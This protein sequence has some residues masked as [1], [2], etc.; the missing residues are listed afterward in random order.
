MLDIRP[1]DVLISPHMLKKQHMEPTPLHLG[2][3]ERQIVESLYRLE[4]AS[5]ADVRAAL[6]DPPSY[7]AVRAVLNLLVH[8]GML[9]VRQEGKRYLYRPVSAK[10][11]VGRSVLRNLVRTFFGSDPAGAVAALL[12]G[13]AGKLSADDLKRIRDMID[14]A[15][16]PPTM[17]QT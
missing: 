15:G 6:P 5:V 2:K 17:G 7:S 16:E 11:K 14:K 3:R 10:E 12:E 8:K 13:S 1:A 4:E 9:I